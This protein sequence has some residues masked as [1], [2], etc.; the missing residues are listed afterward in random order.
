MK[1]LA[2]SISEIGLQEPVQSSVTFHAMSSAGL[3]PFETA[4]GV[5]L[6]RSLTYCVCY[7]QIDVLEVEGLLYGF[8]GCHR[9]EVRVLLHGS[10][11]TR[12]WLLSRDL[13]YQISWALRL[14][15]LMYLP[16]MMQP[17]RA[18]VNRASRRQGVLCRRIRSWERRPFCVASGKAARQH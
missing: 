2:E 10:Q 9:Y 11:L 18:D 6:Y 17:S 8:S 3:H 5:G 16:G 15:V 13:S 1:A 12:Q 14:K 7:L 4:G